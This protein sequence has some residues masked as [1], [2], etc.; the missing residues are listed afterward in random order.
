MKF[1]NKI[2]CWLSPMLL[3]IV[4]CK[5]LVEVP[6][7][8]TSMRS[9]NVFSNDATSIAV[10]TGIYTSLSQWGVTYGLPAM[11]VYPGL[12]SDEQILYAP[13]SNTSYL[14][15]YQNNLTV[16]NLP[17]GLDIWTSTYGLIYRCNLAIEGLTNNT[18]LTPAVEQQ[19]M[20]EAKF[21]RAFCYFYLVNL[22]GDVPLVT[23]TSYTINATL[24]RTP[25]DQVY[26]QMIADL[27][28]A[29]GVMSDHY[30]DATLAN[31]SSE[32][33]RPIKWAANALLARTYLYTGKYDSAEMQAT[34]V[35][36]NTSLY[37]LTGR[38][39]VFLKNSNEAIWQI[40]PVNIGQNTSDGLFFILPSSG[41]NY[42]S[43][44]YL[45]NHLID[46]FETGDQRL[47]D[48]VNSV[49]VPVGGVP[50]TYFYPYKYKV[51]APNV[52][53]TEYE[54]VMRLAEQYLIRA[55][56][57][58]QQGHLSDA[59]ADLNVVR[60]RAGLGNTG[61]STQPELF[62]AVQHERQTELFTEWGNRWLDLKR[63]GKVDAI[64][65][66]VTP[67][68]GGVWKTTQQFYPVPLTDI[69]YDPNMVQNPG[70]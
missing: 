32:R 38:D 33:V 25:K 43:T 64:M 31:A 37:R 52:A 2:I 27:T 42:S 8:T 41:P 61:A 13:G 62:A 28:E 44:T 11:S 21:T 20:G 51:N 30:V 47:V 46:S 65:T 16:A 40:Q 10:L 39:T 34:A 35:I 68:K 45:S 1:S 66:L 18:A 17:G 12:S 6:G 56:A 36:N 69:K 67:E 49:T 63:T 53:V 29:A 59:A 24:P 57:R 3:F 22:Y 4:S 60:A 70:Y 58:A 15:V 9:A 50:T 5:K 14:P 55:E 23:S 48:W 26:R 19:L 54:M 7:P